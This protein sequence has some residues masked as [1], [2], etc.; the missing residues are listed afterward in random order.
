[1][2]VDAQ[3]YLETL[4]RLE[5]LI[6]Q[7]DEVIPGHGDVLDAERALAILR[8]DREYVRALAADGAAA[9]LPLARRT[10]AQRAIHAVNVARLGGS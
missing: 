8:E 9:P 4:G 6:G 2:V 10:D 5:V 7:V 1:M 3:A